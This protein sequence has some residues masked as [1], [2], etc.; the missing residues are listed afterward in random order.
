MPAFANIRSVETLFEEALDVPAL[1]RERWLETRC[2]GDESLLAAVRQL[3][4]A[5]EQAGGFLEGSKIEPLPQPQLV[6]G[7]ELL[8]ELGR[9]GSGTVF[10]ARQ[11]EPVRREVALKLLNAGLDSP[12]RR[13]RFHA[14][15][16]VLAR[17][18]HENIARVFDAGVSAD[19]RPF[20]VMELV[21]GAPITSYCDT[22]RLSL[23]ARLRLFIDVCRAVHHAHQKG[24]IHRDL[25]P[26]NVLVTEVD[27]H[28]VPKVI[29]FGIAKL[30]GPDTS[31]ETLRTHEA[32]ML[33]TPAYMAPEQFGSHAQEIDTRTDVF[34]LG[35]VLCELLTG[36]P[37]RDP[38]AFQ[39][40]HPASWADRVRDT[41]I[42][43]P[44]RIV[45]SFAVEEKT[46][47][48][49]ARGND[50]SEWTRLLRGD[51]D[52]IA[53]KCLDS[54]PARRYGSAEALAADIARFLGDRA[55]EARPPDRIYLL[56]KFL[57][58][59]RASAA[60]AALALLGLAGGLGLAMHSRAV[61]DAARRHAE[62]ERQRAKIETAIAKAEKEKAEAIVSTLYAGLFANKPRLGNPSPENIRIALKELVDGFPS[63]LRNDPVTERRLRHLLGFAL[64]A[65]GAHEDARPQLERA[66]VLCNKD[67]G[68][69]SLDAA[70][71]RYLLG[72]VAAQT[73]D[74]LTAREHYERALS[75][76]ALRDSPEDSFGNNVRLD[77]AE[78]A[79]NQ[80]RPQ[81][82]TA[83][84]EEALKIVHDRRNKLTRDDDCEWR[85][86]ALLFRFHRHH[87]RWEN[88]ALIAQ[89]RVDWALAR[90]G[91][92]SPV[93]WTAQADLAEASL[94]SGRI[95]E[96][97]E[98]LNK[99]RN[100]LRREK[101]EGEGRYWDTL[102]RLGDAYARI[103][104]YDDA[105]A[106]FQ[107]LLDLSKTNDMMGEYR[108]K[109]AREGIEKIRKARTADENAR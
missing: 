16:H 50:S 5:S 109:H 74:W 70:R 14:E 100:T 2:G 30:I 105:T 88:A 64:C 94:G 39:R 45:E 107:R 72:R 57:R 108:V 40:S 28:A 43:S 7:F 71:I 46:A 75:V 78:V 47:G 95:H 22:R 19:G 67:P 63:S 6:G 42:R 58:R 60:A 26:S 44:S 13:A 104:N 56:R 21:R 89:A 29:D 41:P 35:A 33:G 3:L 77:L 51:L 59:H 84:A 80:G 38:Q 23:R 8:D 37:P 69:D 81:E 24:V 92:N 101:R 55:I 12:E 87:G 49:S 91:P 34:A 73:R 31:E 66:L 96:A 85:T 86:L 1:E 15:R 48:S 76:A 52:W 106:C 82:A 93:T 98:L 83:M 36:R 79:E 53:L 27:G 4:D 11:N 97:I 54:E 18:E 103:G 20:F 62:Q 99:A 32:S 10:R 61:A 65:V 68:P 17:M 9:G 25:K 102:E 90:F